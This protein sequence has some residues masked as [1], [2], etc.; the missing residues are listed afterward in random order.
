[1]PTDATPKGLSATAR[2]AHLQEIST[3][4]SP[5]AFAVLT[6]DGAGWHQVGDRLRV[7]DNI[8]LLGCS[9]CRPIHPN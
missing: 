1:M 6:L 2:A 4:V 7:P 9:I 3:Q 8:G 5:G